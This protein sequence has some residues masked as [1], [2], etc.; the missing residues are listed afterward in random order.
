MNWLRGISEIAGTFR[1]GRVVAGL[2]SLFVLSS[3]SYFLGSKADD[4]Q[5]F[6]KSGDT[7]CVKDV[8]ANV[9][10]WFEEGNGD[11]GA[12][13]DCAVLAIDEFT[14]HVVG[15][16]D[17]RYTRAELANFF[18]TYLAQAGSPLANDA[19][20]WTHE[21]MTM[22]Q[23][24]FGGGTDSITKDE[25][26]RIRAFLL[27]AKPM[28][29]SLTP[30]IR[31]MFF[32]NPK[33][34]PEDSEAAVGAIDRVTE[35]I[36][37]EFD[38]SVA[39][40]PT[41]S[42]ESMLASARRLGVDSSRLNEWVPIATAIKAIVVGGEREKI[43]AEEWT[44]MLK[45]A[46][47][48]WAL[49]LRYKY[50]VHLNDEWLG[51]N[52]SSTEEV[53]NGFVDLVETA[54]RRHPKGIPLTDWEACVTAF[55]QKGFLPH[56]LTPETVNR[57]LPILFG[58]LLYGNSKPDMRSKSTYF[59]PEQFATLKRAV[60]DWTLGEKIVISTFGRHEKLDH[61]SLVRELSS[62]AALLNAGIEAADRGFAHEVR[63]D[64]IEFYSQGRPLVHMKLAP[65]CA[66]GSDKK[67]DGGSALVVVPKSA[68]PPATRY[69]LDKLN[70]IRILVTTVMRGW[71]HDA[72]AAKE[73][74]GLKE[75]E[76]QEVYLDVKDLGAEL[77][78]MD[79]RNNAAGIRTFMEGGI[80]TSV[81]D[82]DERMSVRE[83][84]EW[85]HFVMGGGGLADDIHETMI[86]DGCGLPTVDVLGKTQLKTS[87]FRERFIFHF[88]DF[89]PNLPNM[90][91][92]VMEDRSGWR[93]RQVLVALE[94][95]GRTR[96]ARDDE[97]VDGS[98]LRSM[99][100][101]LHYAESLFARHDANG[102]DLLDHDELERAF[103]ILQRFIKKMGNGKADG[104]KMQKAIY[105]YLLKHGEP[106]EQNLMDG[107]SVIIRRFFPKFF[108]NS[109]DRMKVLG[110]MGSFGKAA[111]Q[112]RLRDIGKFLK[113][114]K[115]QVRSILAKRKADKTLA[116]L[117]QCHP[118]ASDLVGETFARLADY[119][120]ADG[121][122]AERFVARGQLAIAS[123]P[124]LK[125]KC[126]PF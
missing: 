18:K 87:C 20:A 93:A 107:G 106:P 25:V 27:R 116:E 68:L 110:V 34:M 19:D 121:E 97:P 122:G 51:D 26:A 78:F 58:K 33:V 60:K 92:W 16:S 15:Q 46:G 117:F 55:G 35:F 50:E 91:R 74:L 41:T 49:A 1:W 109:A 29:I 114:N 101:I 86:K 61:K 2:V 112:T 76:A 23:L 62:E 10:H 43:R 59:G 30:H 105:S 124:R 42:A 66:N 8:G 113:Q 7:T 5:P 85:F 99:V 75:E 12:S 119:V 24:A 125:M 89:F 115:G 36:A 21:A 108:K 39:E 94:D 111:K 67:C 38:E 40:R 48:A 56:G 95:A 79:V 103:P 84:V 90:T 70:V 17:G 123:E 32:K 3:C 57:L 63:N 73:L 72:R 14:H 100:P 64:L 22:K 80:F 6:Q 102:N 69:D 71:A 120:M 44:P 52:F 11:I 77:G 96:G 88:K 13:V 47:R 104:E 28:L 4:N 45:A 81:S 98:E 31:T 37:E 118:E 54:V 83:A 82:G 9:A 65:K 53:L 126:L